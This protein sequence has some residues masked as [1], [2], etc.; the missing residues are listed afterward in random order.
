MVSATG[1]NERAAGFWIRVV[2]TVLDLVAGGL[3][4]A[5]A[6][7]FLNSRGVYIQ[8]ELWTVAFSAVLS[9]LFIWRLSASP[10]KLALGLR[11][12]TSAGG[13]VSLPRALFREL[14]AKFVSLLCLLLG[15]V[16][17]GI[18]RDKRG[19]HDRM[20]HTCV[21]Y[22]PN[23]RTRRRLVLTGLLLLCSLHASWW[24]Y[25]A[26]SVYSYVGRPSHQTPPPPDTAPASATDVSAVD[27]SLRQHAADWLKLNAQPPDEYVLRTARDRRITIIGEI[28]G[29]KEYLEFLHGLLP[30][31]YAEANVT[32]LAL[33]WCRAEDNADLHRLV[34]SDHFDETSLLRIARRSIWESWGY[35]EYWSVL[36]QVWRINHTRA[37]GRE[38]LRV[39]GVNSSW[40]GPSMALALE[41][42]AAERP[43]LVRAFGDLFFSFGMD[44]VYARNVEKG[45]LG[46][47]G[48]CLVW[49]G[50]AHSRLKVWQPLWHSARTAL[51]M[52]RMG[53]ILREKYGDQ[54]AQIMLHNDT[55]SQAIC[56]LMEATAVDAGCSPCGFDVA[57][58]PFGSLQDRQSRSYRLDPRAGFADFAEGYV[59]LGRL[60]SLTRCTWMEGFVSDRMFGRNRP[61]YE[62]LCERKLANSREANIYLAAT[63][64]IL[65]EP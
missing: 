41:D 18:S 61:F 29:K 59:L 8:R 9:A 50:A 55:M 12:R 35:Q 45:M 37:R 44:V 62:L 24:T 7:L 65:K 4:V 54:V 14:P 3:I 23:T 57:A 49:V 26:I 13:D 60:K 56:E 2:A 11:V 25:R 43:R 5:V 64:G 6:A 42:G 15:F 22:S 16:R 52:P 58:S 36:E 31:L 17:I 48:H 46:S 40:D 33:E 39:I 21:V 34:T 1:I 10:G 32:C 28:H 63:G 30:R 38:A 27:G 20:A 47:T 51:A 53:T 19:Y